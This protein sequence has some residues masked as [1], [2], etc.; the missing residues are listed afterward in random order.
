MMEFIKSDLPA[1][2][3]KS[4][5]ETYLKRLKTT[6]LQNDLKLE[7]QIGEILIVRREAMQ[8]RGRAQKMLKH[9]QT[10]RLSSDINLLNAG[11]GL[12]AIKPKT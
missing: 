12:G 8:E 6:E 10:F 1:V 11:G 4:F 9:S 2:G 5:V 3:L 7:N